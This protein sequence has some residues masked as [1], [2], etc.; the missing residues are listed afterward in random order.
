[1]S[2]PPD[3][4]A[5]PASRTRNPLDDPCPATPLPV[6][7]SAPPCQGKARA[8]EPR[9]RGVPAEAPARTPAI[10]ACRS[11]RIRRLEGVAGF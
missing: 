3:R 11:L 9:G 6:P 1:M 2:R 4:Q 7:P 5:R 10:A 8:A